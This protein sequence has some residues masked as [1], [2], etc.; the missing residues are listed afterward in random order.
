VEICL[1]NVER[2]LIDATKTSG[3]SAAAL[4]ELSIEEAAKAWMLY[5]RLLFQGRRPRFSPRLSRSEHA[6]LDDFLESQST[7]LKGLDNEIAAA[8]WFHKVKLRFLSFLFRYVEKVLPVLGKKGDLKRPAEEVHGPAIRISESAGELN[9]EGAL[10]LLRAFRLERL[11][12]LDAVKQRGFYVGLTK[13]GDL[14]SPDIDPVPSQLLLQLGAFLI[15]TLKGE[16]IA[17]TK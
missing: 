6:E 15:L 4:A 9:T 1:L 14:V 2:L 11:T 16:L 10:S 13:R 17:L 12:E 8:F 3:P 7:Y 5:F